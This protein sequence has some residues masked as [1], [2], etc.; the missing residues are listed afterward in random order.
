[1]QLLSEDG[2]QRVGWFLLSLIAVMAV[3]VHV[4]LRLWRSPPRYRPRS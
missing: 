3:I 4:L 1:M 2:V